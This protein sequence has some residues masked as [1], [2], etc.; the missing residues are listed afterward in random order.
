LPVQIDREQIYQEELSKIK[1]SN[2]FRGVQTRENRHFGFEVIQ[3]RELDYGMIDAIPELA[4]AVE[5]E[6]IGYGKP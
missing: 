6:K 3:K 5:Q 4:N 1:N 2:L